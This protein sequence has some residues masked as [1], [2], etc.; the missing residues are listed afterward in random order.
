MIVDDP[1]TLS[2]SNVFLRL[3]GI[4]PATPVALKLEGF[5]VTGSIKLKTARAM[6]ADVEARGLATPG[7]H[8]LV[9]SSSGNLGVALAMVCRRRGYR[10]SCITDPN[11]SPA[12]LRA[13]RAYGAD[14]VVIDRPDANGGYLQARIDY[15]KDLLASSPTN[16]WLNQHGCAANP[17]AHYDT[18]AR[19][20]LA[21]FPR[22]D[23]VFCGT[24]STGTMMGCVRRFR[25]DSPTTR[26]IAVDPVGS[27]SFRTPAARRMIPG[28]GS[29]C[30][31]AILED[32][33]AHDVIHVSEPAAVSMCYEV[34]L[35]HGLLVGGS[36]GSVLAAV[37]RLADRIEPGA[38]VVALSPD[39]GEKYLDTIYD[40][41]W[42][43]R[44][45]GFDP[46]RERRS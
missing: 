39:F 29:S 8:T 38:T 28:I 20:I 37:R 30:R 10:F 42:V 3:H 21:E 12:N 5:C 9:E 6:I 36:T 19:E 16:V 25:E 15:I 34:A 13:M 1:L 31:P 11:V 4:L 45:Y 35:E 32:G 44:N 23:Y 2:F 43:I 14:V 18:T 22:P 24:G 7:V 40:R 27:V 17:V 46:N 33:M 41:D 26:V